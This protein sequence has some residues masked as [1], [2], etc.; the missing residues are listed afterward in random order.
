MP[1]T[2]FE[3]VFFYAVGYPQGGPLPIACREIRMMKS[4]MR[5]LVTD[6]EVVAGG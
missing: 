3:V 1:A 5:V 6:C 4:K 2:C